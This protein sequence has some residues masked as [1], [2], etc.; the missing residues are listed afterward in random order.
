MKIFGIVAAALLLTALAPA[1]SATVSKPAAPKAPVT[2][3]TTYDHDNS[4]NGFDPNAP[5]FVGGPFSTWNKAVDQAVYAQPLAF[6]GV[7]FVATMGDS[8][9]AFNATDG[10]QLWA[11]VGLGSASTASYC[12]FNPGHIGIMGTPVIDAATGIL[13]AVGLDTTG[14]DAYKMYALHISDGTNVTGFPVTLS[15]SPAGQNQR[16]A[17]SLANGHVYVAFGG[18]LGDCPTYHPLVLSVPTGGV[19]EDHVYQP[20]TSCMDAAGIWGA[21]GPAVDGSGN[22]YVATGNG[23]GCYGSTSYPCTNTSWDHG[24]GVIKLSPTL[25]ET[26]FW[27]PDNATQS[28]CDLS[29]TDT[30]VGSVGSILLP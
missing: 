25:A 9:Y 21:S 24:N 7:V 28:W 1:A 15:V 3:W 30:D 27:A 19:A 16:A 10:T 5:A 2:G 20:Q 18:W 23:N 17:L 26:S 6:N 29:R 8:V 12:A 4:R 13:Y 22:I 14:S 11:R